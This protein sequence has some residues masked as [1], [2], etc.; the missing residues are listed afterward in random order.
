MPPSNI[1]GSTMSNLVEIKY[2]KV[3]GT[4]KSLGTKYSTKLYSFLAW[5]AEHTTV[6]PL[7]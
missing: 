3:I 4:K 1:F 7:T 2:L 5:S 6:E